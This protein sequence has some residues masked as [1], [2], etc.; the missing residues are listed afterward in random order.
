MKTFSPSFGSIAGE[1]ATFCTDS[2]AIENFIGRSNA[3]LGVS[4]TVGA[5]VVFAAYCTVAGVSL[6][7]PIV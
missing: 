5:G 1:T 6:V 7:F 3:T 4:R 2:P